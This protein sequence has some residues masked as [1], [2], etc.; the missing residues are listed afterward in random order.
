MKIL[1]LVKEIPDTAQEITVEKL[2]GCTD[3]DVAYS[4]NIHDEYAIEAGISLKEKYGGE[5]VCYWAGR[6]ETIKNARYYMNMGADRIVLIEQDHC[7]AEETVKLLE[8]AICENDPDYDLILAGILGVDQIRGEV[9]GRLAARL[10]IPLIQRV[11]TI[12]VKEDTAD[13]NDFVKKRIF[14]CEREMDHVLETVEI[15]SPVLMTIPKGINKPRLPDLS[16]VFSTDKKKI[17]E[18]C[19]DS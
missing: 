12:K 18:I 9:P 11:E 15:N 7:G 1:I 14:I 6:K 3:R 2:Q 16:F 8:T 17:V 5:V 10:Q 13:P 4:I 19:R